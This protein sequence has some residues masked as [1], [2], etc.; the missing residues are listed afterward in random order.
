MHCKAHKHERTLTIFK[1]AENEMEAKCNVFWSCRKVRVFLNMFAALSV[2]SPF[3]GHLSLL[4][5]GSSWVLSPS[6]QAS[7]PLAGR[8]DVSVTWPV[9]MPK[10]S[11]EAE[12]K[13]GVTLSVESLEATDVFWRFY[14]CMLCISMQSE[15]TF[16]VACRLCFVRVTLWNRSSSNLFILLW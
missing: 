5:L 16:I 2:D 3:L 12:R 8:G 15:C 7:N 14:R 4:G 1:D 10:V 13:L 9:Q 11:H 6:P